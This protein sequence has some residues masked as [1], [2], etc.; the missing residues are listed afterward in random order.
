[1]LLEN[2]VGLYQGIK[3]QKYMDKTIIFTEKAPAPIGPYSQAVSSGGM[4]YLSGQI[5]LDPESGELV[6]DDIIQETHRVMQNISAL[7]S[8]KGISFRNVIKST[9]FLKD[10]DDF[11]KVNEVYGSYFQ[12][13]YPARETIEVSRLPKDVHVEISMIVS[14]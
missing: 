9:I 10:M 14:L 8:E 11:V 6:I 13:E 12:G 5:A 7:L 2:P 1:M 4:M 3:Q